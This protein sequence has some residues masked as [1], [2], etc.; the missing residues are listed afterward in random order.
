MAN[1]IYGVIFPKGIR[2]AI[3]SLS[4]EVI[5]GLA[6]RLAAILSEVRAQ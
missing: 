3:C 2:I 4:L 6:Y 5:D 1:D